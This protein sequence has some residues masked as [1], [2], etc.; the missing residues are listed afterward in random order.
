MAKAAIGIRIGNLC[1]RYYI[2]TYNIGLSECL[3]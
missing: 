3:Y 1:Y 2:G